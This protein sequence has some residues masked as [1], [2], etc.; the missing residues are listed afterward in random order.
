MT[1]DFTTTFLVDQSTQ[2][3]FNAVTNIRGWWQG[4][5]AEQI[6]GKTQNLNDEFIFRAGD[7]AHHTRQKLVELIP[8]KRVVWLVT[9]SE[10]TFIKKQDEWHGTRLVFDISNKGKKTQL[11]FT[12]EGLVPEVE[13]YDACSSAWQQYLEEKLLSL[14]K[15]A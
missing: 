2:E 13:C 9:F 15:S 3:V 11:K 6:E 7:G 4:L 10:L 8:G 12:H 14:I 1:K 5:Y